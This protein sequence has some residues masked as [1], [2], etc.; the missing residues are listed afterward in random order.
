MAPDKTTC[1]YL[2]PSGLIEGRFAGLE[3]WM[4][5]EKGGKVRAWT[6][7]GIFGLFFSLDSEIACLSCTRCA[8]L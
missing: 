6:G 8:T 3:Y 7:K 4:W 5:W 2:P 1:L